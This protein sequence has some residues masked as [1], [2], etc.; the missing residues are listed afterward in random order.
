MTEQNPNPDVTDDDTEGHM[1]HR[2]PV[3]QG[4]PEGQDSMD[5]DVQG[6]ARKPRLD[7]DDE[8]DTEGHF[9]KPR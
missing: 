2:A 4:K 9:R 1:R 8:D 6:H 7:T 3:R 5:D